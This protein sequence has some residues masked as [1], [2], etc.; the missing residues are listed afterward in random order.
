M[1]DAPAPAAAPE[2][3]PE[4]AAPSVQDLQV[5][6]HNYHVPVSSQTLQEL[7]PDGKVDPQ[8]A[9]AFEEYL[10]TV[11]AGLYPTLAPQIRQGIPTAYLLD[12]YRQMGK[13][14]LGPNFEPNFQNDPNARAA[15]EGGVDPATGRPAPMSL[16]QWQAHLKSDPA[17]GYDQ[18][19]QG[20]AEKR[21]VL[22]RIQQAFTQG[23]ES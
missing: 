14:V 17:F 11:A 23:G 13:Q 4:Q 15:L 7:A 2:A 21:Q 9:Q 19:P 6:A 16:S 3:A 22:A 8:K 18:T 5:L 12:P 10:K 20:Q 1:S